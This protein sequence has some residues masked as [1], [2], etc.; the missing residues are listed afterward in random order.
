MIGTF[1]A[2]RSLTNAPMENFYSPP[3]IKIFDFFNF[4]DL[5]HSW[6][7]GTLLVL[8]FINLLVCTLDRIPKV[9]NL[10]NYDYSK[11][12]LG[13]LL[14]SPNKAVYSF[15][16]KKNEFD[17][18]LKGFPNLKAVTSDQFPQEERFF[19]EKGKWGRFNFLWVHAG[20]LTALI[21]CIIG[22]ISGF[23]GA[24][25]LKKNQS[26][27]KFIVNLGAN[28]TGFLPFGF[29]LV[30]TDFQMEYYN[31]S[32][33][34]KQYHS[35]L[36]IY[37]DGKKAHQQTISVNHP[38]VYDGISIYYFSH[39][40]KPILNFIVS[41]DGK[42]Y[43][44]KAGINEKFLIEDLGISLLPV[45]FVDKDEMQKQNMQ[46][47]A[48]LASIVSSK[49]L[50]SPEWFVEGAERKIETSIGTLALTFLG[51]E[52]GGETLFQVNKNPGTPLIWLGFAILSVGLFLVSFFA[53][54][55]HYFIIDRSNHLL[56]VIFTK[57]KL[58]MTLETSFQ[59]TLTRLDKCQGLSRKRDF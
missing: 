30:L 13:M 33:K 32:E 18:I 28:K 54:T 31:S 25:T 26:E 53:H 14:N 40:P 23:D 2:Q 58:Q 29:D 12:P 43:P 20:L 19:R 50:A 51:K 59:K 24:V 7:F 38:L 1:V 9:I 21:G 48:V 35:T 8:F 34:I 39:N 52:D 4:F 42:N 10:F 57:D 37:K 47:T 36:E 6:W 49:G 11:V 55:R 46:G 17:D 56:Y 44:I 16:D 15:L 41:A 22:A 27:N 5:Y 45:E 3:I